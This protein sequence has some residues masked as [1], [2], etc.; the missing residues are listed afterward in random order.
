MIHFSLNGLYLEVRT[1]EIS[2]QRWPLKKISSVFFMLYIST[3]CTACSINQNQRFYGSEAHRC[4]NCFN[5]DDSFSGNMPLLQ[6][7]WVCRCNV[8]T[9]KL[10]ADLRLESISLVVIFSLGR[11]SIIV[12]RTCYQCWLSSHPITQGYRNQVWSSVC[13]AGGTEPGLFI[14]AFSSLP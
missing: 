12:L 10:Q 9:E 2:K 8:K 5:C 14:S 13:D 4:Q 6:A 7:K 11:I 1:W 3:L